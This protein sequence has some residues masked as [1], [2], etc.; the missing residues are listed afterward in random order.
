VDGYALALAS[1]ML[2][3]G[4]VRDLRGH[5]SGFLSGSHAVALAAAAL[6]VVVAGAALALFKTR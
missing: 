4:T 3:G 2:A 5:Q 6:Y 1:L